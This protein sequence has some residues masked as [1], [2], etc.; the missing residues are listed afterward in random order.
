MSLHLTPYEVAEYR[1]LS[2]AAS[3]KLI[4][5]G[6]FFFGVLAL[7]AVAALGAG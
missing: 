1:R 7:V 4:L 5:A 6:L 2:P 3:A